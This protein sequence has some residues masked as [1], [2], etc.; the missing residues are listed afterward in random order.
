MADSFGLWDVTDGRIGLCLSELDD[1][2][3]I[4][5]GPCY[6][7]RIVPCQVRSQPEPLIRR[8]SYGT[9][10][11]IVRDI[12]ARSPDI[13]SLLLLGTGYILVRSPRLESL[14]PGTSRNVPEAG[15]PASL[16]ISG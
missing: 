12:R 10:S 7:S 5:K 3:G 9:D 13:H 14:L 11:C 6:Y 4:K 1:P 15:I 8:P 16:I 2:S